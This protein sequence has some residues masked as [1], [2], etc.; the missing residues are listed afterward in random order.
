MIEINNYDNLDYILTNKESKLNSIEYEKL[1]NYAL[2][3]RLFEIVRIIIK[4]ESHD[5]ILYDD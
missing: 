3:L 1:K 5:F 4:F 2:T